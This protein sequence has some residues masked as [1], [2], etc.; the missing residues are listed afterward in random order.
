MI[1]VDGWKIGGQKSLRQELLERTVGEILR[2]G[3]C[4]RAHWG[5]LLGGANPKEGLQRPVSNAVEPLKYLA[6]I[7]RKNFSDTTPW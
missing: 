4:S 5:R 7:V 2:R 6:N 1:D 3:A